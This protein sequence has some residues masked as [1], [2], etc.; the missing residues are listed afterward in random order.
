M[1][2]KQHRTSNDG[3][4]LPGQSVNARGEVRQAEKRPNECRD[5]AGHDAVRAELIAKVKRVAPRD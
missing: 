1:T 5:D 3:V 4:L 2:S